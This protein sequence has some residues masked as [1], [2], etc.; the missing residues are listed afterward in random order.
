MTAARLNVI[1]LGAGVQSSAMA[2]MAAQG[3]IGPMPDFAIF[4]DTG[5]EPQSIYQH[6]DW[7][8]AQLPFAVVRARR[9]GPDLGEM[10]IAIA[11]TPGLTRTAI[12]PWFTKD[13]D[14]MLPQQCSKEFKTRVVARQI[15][16]RLG[17]SRPYRGAPLAE[18][19][20]GISR[21]EAHRQKD[22]ETRFLQH[23]YP[24]I[25]AGLT[26]RDCIAWLTRRGYPVPPKS[27]CIFCPWTDIERWR[28]RKKNHPEDWARA[29]A[30]DAA[31]RPGYAGMPG[32]AYVH[33]QHLP[34]S[35][36]DL[37]SEHDGQLDL[38]GN[39]CEGMC[40]V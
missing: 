28:D 31:I 29:V 15:R 24:L 35:E 12:P 13:P 36:V 7:L 18:L 6:L 1:S 20:L 2:L 22:S 21:D 3:D 30:F 40:G 39:E 8:T 19:W 11:H 16:A 32:T 4:A 9:P 10:S 14:G 23:R 34:L 38:F 33:R 37:A 27:A 5:W 25:E 17:L 26:R